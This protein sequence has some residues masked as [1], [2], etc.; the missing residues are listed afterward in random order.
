MEGVAL[1]WGP[2]E[3]EFWAAGFRV[4]VETEKEGMAPDSLF[5]PGRSSSIRDASCVVACRDWGAV[6][7]VLL[8]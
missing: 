1:A 6:K 7:G 8:G 5:F 2:S 4:A 3:C